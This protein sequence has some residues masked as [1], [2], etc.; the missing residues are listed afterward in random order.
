[1]HPDAPPDNDGSA[2][3][4]RSTPY[5]ARSPAASDRLG[6]D[7][8]ADVKAVLGTAARQGI[9]AYEVLLA[10]SHG[11]SVL[12]VGCAGTET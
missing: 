11:V 12:H 9:D 1:M 4:P 2:R 7:L 10:V 6:G 8:F 3:E 5:T